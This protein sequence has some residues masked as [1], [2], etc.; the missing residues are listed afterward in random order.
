MRVDAEAQSAHANTPRKDDPDL[1]GDA[2]STDRRWRLPAGWTRHP[3]VHLLAPGVVYLALVRIGLLVL[4]WMADANDVSTTDARTVWDGQWFLGI[5]E[6]GYAGVPPTLVD[7]FGNRSAETPLAFFPGYPLLVRWVSELPGA[8]LVGAAFAVSTVSGVACAYA[9][10]RLGEHVGG[11]HRAGLL[12]VALFAAS[13]MAVVLSMAYSE[14]LFCALAAWAL[15]GVVER[16]WLV[17]GLCAAAAGL[18]R[19]TAGALV[20]A[21]GLA[22]LV[23]VLS[24]RDGWRPWVAGLLAPLGLLAYLGWVATSTGSLTGWFD[25]QERGWDSRFDGGAATLRFTL[26]VLASAPS[27]L[28]VATVAILVGAVVLLLVGIRMGVSWPLMVYAAGVLMMDVGSNGL[29][30]SKARLLLPA[31]TLLLPAAVALSRR[32]PGTVAAVLGGV[33]VT[34]SWFGAYALTAWPYAI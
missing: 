27:V 18:V 10:A 7:A 29:M 23:A 6:Y 34:G 4:G 26:D 14:A 15:V 16:R 17:A 33:V 9:L 31:F 11:S 3:A 22:A 32:R 12:T 24:R 13:P 2:G 1:G 25:L 30:N 20:M 19:P 5:A 21:V 8:G 28:E